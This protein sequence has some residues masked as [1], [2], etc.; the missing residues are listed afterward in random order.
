[1][2]VLLRQAGIPSR[3]AIGYTAGLPERRLPVDHHQDAHAWVEV[4]FAGKGWVTFDP[5][6]LSDGRAYTP[7]YANPTDSDDPDAGASSGNNTSENEPTAEKPLPKDPSSSPG[8]ATGSQSQQDT[9]SGISWEA[10]VAI[11]LVLAGLVIAGVAVFLSRRRPSAARLRTTLAGVGFAV[12]VLAL[13]FAVATVSWWLSVLA[14][15][16]VGIA[17]P[18]A[19]RDWRR[20]AR[21]HRVAGSGQDAA[22]AAWAEL[23]AESLDRGL[24]QQRADT[25]RATAR[26]LVRE[27]GLDEDGKRGM[28]TMVSVLERSWYGDGTPDPR[29]GEA[30]DE[31]R[32]SMRRNAPLAFKAKMLPRSV[33]RRRRI[34]D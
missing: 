32:M 11:A 33:L 27:H 13:V 2:G 7:A 21:L 20:R 8:S 25:V 29:L 23:L 9:G 12:W 5:T 1:M 6:P 22:D 15:I 31:V 10:W 14:L 24:P 28:R 19:V 4:F 17:A 3:V 16:V 30:L 18:R 34:P 26:R